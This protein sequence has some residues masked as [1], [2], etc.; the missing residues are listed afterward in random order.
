MMSARSGHPLPAST[1]SLSSKSRPIH[2]TELRSNFC[3]GDE[4]GF[5][6]FGHP[7]L[8]AARQAMSEVEVDTPIEQLMRESQEAVTEADAHAVG[9]RTKLETGNDNCD[10]VARASTSDR[11]ADA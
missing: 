10:E 8:A 6:D 3:V 5:E 7:R 1:I 11:E 4:V 9:G 2:S